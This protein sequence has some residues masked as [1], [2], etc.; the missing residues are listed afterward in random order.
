MSELRF[1]PQAAADL[2]RAIAD[3]GGN[4]VFAIGDVQEGQVHAITVTCR[5]T[6]SSVTALV[7]R[8]RAGQVVVHNHP[9]GRLSPSEPDLALAHLYGED[10]VGV[11]IVDNQVTRSTWV[12]E[13]HAPKQRPVDL[14]RLHAFFHEALPSVL[15]G[16]EPRPQQMAMAEH[17]AM[18]LDRGEPLLCEAGTGTGKSLAYLAPAALW[19]LANESKV[20][21]STHTRALQGQLLH[22]DL[23]L[24]AKAGL[25]VV[26][27]VLEGRGNYLCRRRLDLALGDADTGEA[28]EEGTD[29]E[30]AALKALQAWSESTSSGSR[31]DLPHL[32]DPEL[33]ERVLSDSDLTLSVKCPFYDRCH[34]YQARRHAAGAH[35][36]VVNHALLLVDLALRSQSG[37]GVLPKYDR[38][39]LDEAHHLESAA[40][41]AATEALTARGVQRAIA[42]LLDRRRKGV[43]TRLV[44]GPGKRL[45]QV[46]QDQL[47]AQA[48]NLVPLLDT[49]SSG[50]ETAL[51]QVG[52]ALE[53]PSEGGGSQPT[54]VRITDEVRR[55][56]A[57]ELDVVPT[58]RHLTSE[59]EDVV[60][61][62]EKLV[63]PFEDLELPE[64]LQQPLLDLNRARRRLATHIDVAL[65]FLDDDPERVRWTAPD[66]GR[67]GV[68]TTRLALAPIEVRDTLRRILFDPIPG[69]T[70][71]S[72]TLTV[73]GRFGFFRS[74]TGF[75]GGNE[76]VFESPF[77]HARQAVLGLPRDLPP[78]NHPDFLRASTD[79]ILAAVEA[80][81]GGAFVLCTSYRAVDHY[82]EA[83]RRRG[84]RTVLAQGQGSRH[85][86]LERFK[87]ERRAVLVGTDSFWEGVSV[88]GEGLR[89]VVIPRLPFRVP[90]EPL[91]QARHERI[92]QRGY[93]PFRAYALPE[94]VIKLRQGY[95]RLI[96]G[97]R[98]R[99]AVVLLDRRIHEK[100]YGR[101]LLSSLPPARRVTGPWRRVEEELRHLFGTALPPRDQ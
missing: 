44:T 12:V 11:V 29:E 32:V 33:W 95:G 70:C 22:S 91:L 39:L 79:A 20:I 96:R 90:T 23:P 87:E 27:A 54:A 37:R 67:R 60:R 84:G 28:D 58:V 82:A 38:V 42:P 56:D 46:Q 41:G 31:S 71:T 68:R 74:R 73:A 75:D 69:V 16:F 43:L 81:D 5:G 3:H 51:I 89:L 26:T 13:P 7:D 8:P 59:L 78:P 36:I 50:V 19:A 65:G 100:A 21:V 15:P 24:L 25:P 93:D 17:V 76:V 99:G 80:S 77:D 57:W 64:A 35:I 97:H 2:R 45:T 4:E 98:D 1:T 61:G 52:D 92:Q 94:A 62:L 83:L 10:G 63:D 55:A 47:S 30:L 53:T 101:I 34:Y 88:K 6:E 66:R 72:A 85:R 14:D 40:T 9:S 48:A 18:A 86:M 49:L